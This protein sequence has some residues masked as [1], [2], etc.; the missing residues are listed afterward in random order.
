M[1]AADAT[2]LTPVTSGIHTQVTPRTGTITIGVWQGVDVSDVSWSKSAT[3]QFGSQV[4]IGTTLVASNEAPEVPQPYGGNPTNNLHGWLQPA[5]S[6]KGGSAT[7][8]DSD[9][10]SASTRSASDTPETNTMQITAPATR[11]RWRRGHPVATSWS[12]SITT[13]RSSATCCTR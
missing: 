4:W 6:A 10:M 3:D 9:M 8:V 12:C 2:T 11:S 7:W 5:P 1:G 13:V